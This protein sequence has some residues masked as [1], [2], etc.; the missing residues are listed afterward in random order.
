MQDGV[1][2]LQG[3]E[4]GFVRVF[5]IVPAEIEQACADLHVGHGD[6]NGDGQ[7]QDDQDAGEKLG[8]E[9][10]GLDVHGMLP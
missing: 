7:D 8:R 1:L 9:S 5:Q 10:D 2:G 3:V 4:H 6:E